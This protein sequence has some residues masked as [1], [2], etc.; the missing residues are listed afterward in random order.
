MFRTKLPPSLI[1]VSMLALGTA[2]AGVTQQQIDADA[3]SPGDVLSAGIGPQGQRYSPLSQI[4]TSNVQNLVPAWSFSFG[5]EK[6]RGQE[7]QPVVYNGK[8]FD[9]ASYSRIFA[10][11][12]KTGMKLWK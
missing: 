2:H 10:L 11:D 3:S 4:N 12:A 8:M 7:S 6:Q 5:G 1:A 9:T